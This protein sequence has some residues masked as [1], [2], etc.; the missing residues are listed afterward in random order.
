[1]FEE[2]GGIWDGDLKEKGE[3]DERGRRKKKEMQ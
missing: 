3:E 1:M 2:L